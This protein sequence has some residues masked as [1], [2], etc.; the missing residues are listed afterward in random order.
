MNITK[1]YEVD[2]GYIRRKQ[3]HCSLILSNLSIF[4]TGTYECLANNG[5]VV[6]PVNIKRNLTVLG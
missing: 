2:L 3:T 6:A 5:A 4:N 1:F